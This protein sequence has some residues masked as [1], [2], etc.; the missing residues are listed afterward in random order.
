[1]FFAYG[2]LS[3]VATLLVPVF[4][5]QSFWLLLIVRTLQVR[6]G[7]EDIPFISCWITYIET[8]T[9]YCNIYFLCRHGCVTYI[10]L[11]N[12]HFWHNRCYKCRMESIG[13]LG[14]VFM[15]NFMPLSSIIYL[16]QNYINKDL[17]LWVISWHLW[18][19]CLWL[20]HFVNQNGAGARSIIFLEA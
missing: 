8:L 19:L 6:I 10:C 4:V 15:P 9:G 18:W 12:T 5:Y 16:F 3:S 17:L 11:E 2:I 7:Q 13:W 14:N 1:M 20:E